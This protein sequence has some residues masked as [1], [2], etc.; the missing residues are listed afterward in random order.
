MKPVVKREVFAVARQRAGLAASSE[1]VRIEP[2]AG[3]APGPAELAERRDRL[4]LGAEALRRL[5][6][7]EVRALVLRAEG[8]SYREICAATGWTYTKV[9]RCLAEGRQRFVEQ[10]AGIE[11]G[12][13]CEP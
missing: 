3:W 10:V 6:P 7:H 12:A 4:R 5:K 1:A 2:L 11:S 8:L 13:E 9:N